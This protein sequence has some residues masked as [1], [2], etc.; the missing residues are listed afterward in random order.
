MFALGALVLSVTMGAISYFTTRH[1]LVSGQENAEIHS[2]SKNATFVQQEI[3]DGYH[4]VTV[5][6]AADYGNTRSSSLLYRRGNWYERQF[7]VPPSAL[8]K[9]LRTMV[10]DGTPASL[11]YTRNGKPVIAVGIPIPAVHADYYEVFALTALSKTLGVLA[12]ALVGAGV[13]TTVL[14]AAL[15]R[16]ASGRSLRPLT[17]VSRAAVAI[18]SGELDTRLIAGR[19]DPDLAALTS[20]FNEMVDQLQERIE[21]E[22]RFASD[23]SHELRSP[24]TTLA[25]SLAVLEAHSADL[26]DASRRAL[27]LLSGD[28]RRFQRLVS[29]LLEISRSDAGTADVSFEEVDPAELVRQAVAAAQRSLAL[30]TPAP[31]VEVDPAL[32]GTR[33][34]VDKRRFERVIANLLENAAHYGGGATVVRV[35]PA[36][37]TNGAGHHVRVSVDDAGPGLPATERGRVF[38]RFYRGHAANMRGAGTGTGLGLALVAEHVRLHGGKVWAEEADGGGARFTIELPGEQAEVDEEHADEVRAT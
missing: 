15:G 8:P 6:T 21:H 20:S 17:G 1:I 32:G 18:A 29:D 33:L 14:G 37:H 23:V 31:R 2:A 12:L 27:E 24:L 3:R 5:L 26:T 4:T 36:P 16:W 34:L 11:T 13:A 9:S 38:E 25:A 28:L 7:S 30:E 10:H 22:T 35:G 19:G